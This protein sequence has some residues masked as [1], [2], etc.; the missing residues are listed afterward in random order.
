[1]RAVLFCLPLILAAAALSAGPQYVDGSGHAVSG[2]DVVAYV[3]LGPVP[4]DAAPPAPVPG[5]ADITAQYNGA[6]FA[7]S[8]LANRDRFLADPARYVPQYDGHCAYGVA[9]G[10]KVPGDPRLWR[11]IDGRLY[12]NLTPRIARAWD[13]DIPGNLSAAAEHWP[14][15]DPMPASADP[16]PRPVPDAPLPVADDAP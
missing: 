9:Q 12:L 8:S 11:I 16:V 7:F 14:G 2:Y 4:D 6:V 1:M 5:R 10:A 15:L 3:D 13:R